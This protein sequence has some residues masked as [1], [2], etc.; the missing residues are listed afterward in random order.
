MSEALIILI[1]QAAVK[2]GPDAGRAIVAIFTKTNPTKDD[3]ENVFVLMEKSYDDYVKPAPPTTTTVTT[4]T[5][6]P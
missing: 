5:P 6:T 1:L 3:W 2:Y 4:V